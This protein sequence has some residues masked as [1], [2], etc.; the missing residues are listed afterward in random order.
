MRHEHCIETEGKLRAEIERLRRT[1]QKVVDEADR[2]G[3]TAKSRREAIICLRELLANA[4][5]EYCE[6]DTTPRRESD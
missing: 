2:I 5:A 3:S 4:N 1:A 6:N